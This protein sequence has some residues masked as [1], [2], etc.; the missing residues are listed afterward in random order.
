MS[1]ELEQLPPEEQF[2]EFIERYQDEEGK[3]KYKEMLKRIVIE[4]KKSLVVDFHDIIDFSQELASLII[5][6]PREYIPK[7][8]KVLKEI[9]SAYAGKDYKVNLRFSNLPETVKLRE[10]RD[11][12][13]GKLIM[14]EGILVRVTQVKERIRK[15]Y[16]RCE[17]CGTIFPV[18][19]NEIYIVTPSSCP[20]E[21]CPKRTGPFTFLADHPDNEYVN[22]QMMVVQEKPEELPAGQLPRSIEVIVEDD[23]VDIA[24]PGDKVT[25]VG[26]VEAKPDKLLRKGSAAIFTI[27]IYANNIEVSQKVLEDIALEPEDVEKIQELAKDPW[28]HKRIVMSIAPSIY[29]LWDI[30]EAIALSLFGGVPKQLEDGT[31]IRGDIHVLII[32]DPG[33]AKS[34]LLQYAARVAPRSVYTT[35]KGSTAAGLTA[36]VVRDKVTG[37][38]YLEAGA[39]VIADGG[40]AVID[41][42]DKMREEDRVAIHEAMEQQ[43]VSIAKAGIVAK[44][45]AR[46]AV[47]AAGN[48]RYGRYL[49]N[50]TVAENINLPPSILSRFDL[51]FVLQDRPDPMNDR[52]LVRYILNVHKEAEKIRPEIPIDLLK[53]YIVYAKKT[54]SPKLTEDAKKIIENFFVDLRSKAANNPE[55]GVPITARQ[56]EA[57]VRMSEAHA[58]MALRNSVLAEDAVEAVR[59][60]LAFLNTVGL[61]V[62]TGRIDIDVILTGRPVSKLSKMMMVSKLLKELAE[63]KECVPLKELVEEARKKGIEAEVVD[64]AIKMFRNDGTIYEKR[65]G[66]FKPASEY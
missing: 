46:C 40:V 26:I 12:H 3:A 59:M 28:I 62:E 24:R 47:L 60:M 53:K 7:F 8:E 54:V 31:R 18:I 44:L 37:E 19:Q 61:D 55:M 50:R 58:R 23:L 32:G 11:I 34:Q 66:C 1:L 43:T 27:R 33:T 36:A 16:F 4:R 21:E 48:P 38:F 39:L 45:N 9:A 10:I 63:G 49:P 64:E 25:I 20:N 29:G 52:R 65:P 13:I 35:G 51:I 30:K 17:A 57:L 2:R 15:A 5:D 42:I 14:I 6:K 22:W 56:L 41:E